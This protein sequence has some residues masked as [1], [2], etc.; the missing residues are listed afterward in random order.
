MLQVPFNIAGDGD[1]NER[2]HDPHATA[3]EKGSSEVNS[4]KCA[5]YNLVQTLPFLDGHGG[6]LL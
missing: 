4:L 6:S 3:S 1:G 2:G 5:H